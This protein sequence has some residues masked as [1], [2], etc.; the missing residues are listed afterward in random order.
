MKLLDAII[1]GIIEGLT[2]FLPV[3]SS[4]HLLLTS[5]LLAINENSQQ[6][7]SV[8][9]QLGAVF[10][11]CI[12][13]RK[14]IISLL[15]FSPFQKSKPFSSVHGILLFS[16]ATLPAV[17]LGFI[18]KSTIDSLFTGQ[19]IALFLIIGSFFI[20]ITESIKKNITVR[21]TTLDDIPIKI[22]FYTGCF[23]CLA[24]FPGFSRSAATIMGAILLGNSR[25]I[26]TKFSFLLSIPIIIGASVLQLIT[27]PSF[28][29]N[30]L[31][32][33]SIS[34]VIAFI[35]SY[36]TIPIII[37][38]LS[39]ISFIPFAFYRIFLAISFLLLM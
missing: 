9:T 22:A 7:F 17:L 31:F 2:E 28:A 26:A 5:T 11:L 19:S 29:E 27:M 10:A 12:Y 37:P 32:F 3:S 16:I 30:E 8:F 39:R 21:Y 13:Y 25:A 35:V 20:L 33:L 23:Q 18:L 1:L 4:G 34:L 6:N 38:L 36:Y 15:S 14:D 24:L